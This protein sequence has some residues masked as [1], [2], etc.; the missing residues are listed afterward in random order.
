MTRAI[1]LVLPSSLRFDIFIDQTLDDG[2]KSVSKHNH[3]NSSH[4]STGSGWQIP[5]FSLDMNISLWKTIYDTLINTTIT[6]QTLQ[7]NAVVTTHQN[8][9]LSYSNDNSSIYS[10]H[11]SREDLK[12]MYTKAG[13]AQ[14]VSEL[15]V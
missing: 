2:L 10:K 5:L 13:V 6:Q 14:L 7:N 11:W 15:C 1:A 8:R 4:N 12:F 3:A 9:G